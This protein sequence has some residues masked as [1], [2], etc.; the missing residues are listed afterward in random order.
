MGD[1]HS[2]YFIQLNA[3]CIL[4]LVVVLFRLRNKRET[5]SARRRVFLRLT[6]VA[7]SLCVSDVCSGLSN[8]HTFTGAQFLNEFGNI[9][10]YLGITWIGYIWMIF[11]NMRLNGLE[12]NHKRMMLWSSIP[13]IAI[14]VVILLNPFIHFMFSI[15][16]ATNAYSRGPGIYLHWVVSWGYLVAAEINVMLHMKKQPGKTAR[17]KLQPL[18]WFIVAP[19]VAAVAQMI[20]PYLIDGVQCTSMQCGVTFSIVVMTF[21]I[22]Q[23]KISMDTLTGLSNR[24]ALE[25]YIG[26]KLTLNKNNLRV[27]MCDVDH[28][29]NINDVLGHLMGDLALKSIGDI[30]KTACNSRNYNVFLCR[31]GGDEFVIAST[32]ADEK[33]METLIHDINEGLNKF[34][35]GSHNVFTLEVS[36]GR[37]AGHFDRFEDAENLIQLADENMYEQKKAKGAQRI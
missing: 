31:Y 24:S 5:L 34:N 33:D 22:L 25:N 17:R 14:S 18:L 21:E 16:A 19:I 27:L 15:D 23:E 20:V 3:L 37:A 7:I 4:L 36:I 26:D 11:V 12:Y 28:F 10:Y 29:K 35:S 32:E 1:Y 13:G 2:I 30:L 9:V 6:W 8:L